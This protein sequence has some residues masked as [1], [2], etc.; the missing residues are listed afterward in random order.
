MQSDWKDALVI[1]LPFLVG[2]F[3]LVFGVTTVWVIVSLG[4][5]PLPGPDYKNKYIWVVFLLYPI[6]IINS[7]LLGYATHI[8]AK[9]IVE[10]Y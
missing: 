5:F 1:M 10:K 2:L 3:T 9:K 4:G 8:L 6:S 7:F